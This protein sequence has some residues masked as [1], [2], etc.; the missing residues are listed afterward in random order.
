MLG[1]SRFLPNKTQEFPWLELQN[2]TQLN[3]Q[4]QT[5][6]KTKECGATVGGWGAMFPGNCSFVR[7]VDDDDLQDFSIQILVQVS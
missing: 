5:N 1:S 3:K 4:Q 6:E 2:Y 7:T